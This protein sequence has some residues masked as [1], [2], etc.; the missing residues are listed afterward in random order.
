MKYLITLL[1]AILTLQLHSQEIIADKW[2]DQLINQDVQRFCLENF[3]Q[4]PFKQPIIYVQASPL[5]PKFLAVA[6]ILQ[7]GEYIINVN[8]IY[9]DVGFDMSRV[10]IHELVHIIQFHEQ[11]LRI[12]G[13]FFIYNGQYYSLDWPYNERP[14]E[15]EADHRAALFCD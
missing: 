7:P 10:M 5:N 4:P 15:I 12:E 14:W 2:C 8:V 1:L 3:K 9:L 11:R 13:E 6:N